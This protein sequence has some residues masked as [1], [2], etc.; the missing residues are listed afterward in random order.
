MSR[1][2]SVDWNIASQQTASPA[3]LWAVPENSLSWPRSQ[4]ENHAVFFIFLSK[5]HPV[6][7]L[8]HGIPAIALISLLPRNSWFCVLVTLPPPL[9]SEPLAS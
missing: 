2:D 6:A 8:A 5:L 9:P 7:V 3:E 4:N 1:K